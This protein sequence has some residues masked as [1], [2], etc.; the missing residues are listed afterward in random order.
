MPADNTHGEVLMGQPFPVLARY[1]RE[2]KLRHEVLAIGVEKSLRQS[3][4]G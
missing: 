1:G 3:A 4:L 2:E